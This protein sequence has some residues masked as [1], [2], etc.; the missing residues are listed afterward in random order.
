MSYQQEIVGAVFRIE[1]LYCCLLTVTLH[2]VDMHLTCLINITYLLTRTAQISAE[3]EILV[4][5]FNFLM[6]EIQLSHL[7]LLSPNIIPLRN[8]VRY[9]RC[10][11]TLST[12]CIMYRVVLTGSEIT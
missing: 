7:L 5:E 10:R 3:V 4:L 11:Q 8:C 1:A 9:C 12:C 6:S 2:L